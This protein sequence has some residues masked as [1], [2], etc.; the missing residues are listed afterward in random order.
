ML[1]TNPDYAQI[2]K[3]PRTQGANL[4]NGLI[5][6]LEKPRVLLQR[7]NVVLAATRLCH[8]FLN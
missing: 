7:E 8:P 6:A 3:P 4:R 5:T 1:G 2:L